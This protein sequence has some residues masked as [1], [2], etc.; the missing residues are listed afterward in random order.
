MIKADK[1][2]PV[3]RFA[4]KSFANY[5]K[6]GKERVERNGNQVTIH[7]TA[8]RSHYSPEVIEVKVGDE[9]TWHITNV[10]RAQDQV[11][12][13]AVDNYNVHGSLEPGETATF[14]FVAPFKIGWNVNKC[15]NCKKC[16][17]ACMVPWVLKDTVN[18]G[19]SEYVISGDCTRCGLCIDACQDAAL[20]YHV[21]YLDKLI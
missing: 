13:F 10:E 8:I 16:Q 11:H 3:V 6:A 19:K 15:S 14:K 7:S 17:A 1:L 9:I 20:Q 21:R 12:G 18:Q 4:K 2:K 5:V